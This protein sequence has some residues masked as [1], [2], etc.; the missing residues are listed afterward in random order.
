MAAYDFVNQLY[1][2]DGNPSGGLVGSVPLDPGGNGLVV[3]NNILYIILLNTATQAGSMLV[4]CSGITNITNGIIIGQGLDDYPFYCTSNTAISMQ[5]AGGKLSATLGT[6]TMSGA[7]T[8]ACG[9][10]TRVGRSIVANGGTLAT[11]TITTGPLSKITFGNFEGPPNCGGYIQSVVFWPS[12]LPDATLK[13][14]T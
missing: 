14:L 7:V 13:G 8:A 2:M 6:G 4:R 11:D 9:F 1:W 12:R 10:D 3:S 5:I